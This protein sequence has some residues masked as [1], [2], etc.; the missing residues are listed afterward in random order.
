MLPSE[1]GSNHVVAGST[2]FTVTLAD[3]QRLGRFGVVR[4]ALYGVFFSIASWVLS[5]PLSVAKAR[6]RPQRASKNTSKR[7]AV[8]QS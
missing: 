5:L 4:D 2:T 6:G 7:R 1:V 8:E 3:G